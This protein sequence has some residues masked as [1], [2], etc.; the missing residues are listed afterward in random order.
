MAS[1]GFSGELDDSAASKKNT[2]TTP[3]CL[4]SSHS[5]WFSKDTK[6]VETLVKLAAQYKAAYKDLS[7]TPRSA[8]TD[9][10]GG[11][12]NDSIILDFT[13]HMHTI[14][15][16]TH[17]WAP[18]RAC[19]T[20]ILSRALRHGVFMPSYPA[21]R[22]LAALGGMVGNNSGGEKSLEYGKVKDFVTELEVVWADGVARKVKP[23]TK[24]AL[25]KKMK[26]KILKAKSTKQIF[27]LCEKKL[28]GNKMP[29]RRLAKTLWATRFGKSGTERPAF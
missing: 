3:P 23:I 13:K 19:I 26:Q 6:D 2:A 9:M 16:V 8:G 12:I 20:A 15:E 21:S 5:L 4:K 7:L 29:N 17:A 10:A 24:A 11:A 18:N 28:R 27:E 1:S 25:D 22:D 14:H